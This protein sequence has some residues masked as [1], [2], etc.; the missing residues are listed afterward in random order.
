MKNFDTKICRVARSLSENASLN[1][2][3]FQV[4]QAQYYIACPLRTEYHAHK[5]NGGVFSTAWLVRDKNIAFLEKEYQELTI[6]SL[7]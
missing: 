2:S 7:V 6:F 1:L 3:N 4:I 5:Q